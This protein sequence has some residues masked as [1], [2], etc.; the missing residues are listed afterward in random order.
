MRLSSLWFF[1]RSTTLRLKLYDPASGYMDDPGATRVVGLP[2]ILLAA[3]VVAISPSFLWTFFDRLHF[4]LLW[5]FVLSTVFSVAYLHIKPI[6]VS[7]ESSESL[8]VE[9]PPLEFI[10]YRKYDLV[11]LGYVV[12]FAASLAVFL[13][14]YL[15]FWSFLPIH[16]VMVLALTIRNKGIKPLTRYRTRVALSILFCLGGIVWPFAFTSDFGFT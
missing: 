6:G 2:E 4:D 7:R 1:P 9:T 3:A 14:P 5:P 13:L 16:S 11:L 15:V 10:V 8:D 12:L